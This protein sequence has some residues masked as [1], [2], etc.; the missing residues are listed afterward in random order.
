MKQKIKSFIYNLLP[1]KIKKRHYQEKLLK[2]GYQTFLNTGKTPHESF[3]SL[4]NLYCMTNGKFNKSF[5]NKIKITNPPHIEN[6]TL[7]GVTGSFTSG[8]F[9]K[10]NNELNENGYVYF[11]QRLSS[12]LCKKLYDFALRTPAGTL[13]SYDNR[14]I[15]DPEKPVSEIYRIPER[16]LINNIDIQE[17]IMDP[18]LINIA[19]NYLGCEPIFD[20]PQMWWSPAFAKEAS[21]KGA[22]QYHF[23]LDRVKW[24]KLFIYVNDVAPEN[25]PHC[26]IKGSHKPGNKPMELL[27]RGYVRIPDSDLKK[28]Y[29]DDE[30]VE[31]C[32]P[33]GTVFAGDTKCWHKGNLVRKGHRLVL[34]FEYTSSL[35]G[36][37]NPKLEV[38]VKNEKFRSFC[39]SNKVYASNIHFN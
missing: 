22:Q 38:D 36:A 31:V 16:D 37:N 7:E 15:Y 10:I 32:A 14:I 23:D 6:D 27:K 20:Y 39:E 12:D 30:F 5:H 25:G 4:I 17:L 28:Y 9:K 26:Y 21:A 2:D 8:D 34:E 3:M 13:S 35:F 29:K 11:A 19:R 24:L 33:A 1:E 18:V